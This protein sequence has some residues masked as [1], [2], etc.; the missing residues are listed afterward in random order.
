M[1]SWKSASLP[2]CGVADIS[3]RLRVRVPSSLPELVALRLLHL[4][5]EIGG[6]HA[7]RFV[8]DDEVP[9]W[10][11][12]QL[13]FQFVGARGHVEPHDEAVAF[14]ER[15][16]GER[17]LDLVAR[18]DVEG[19]AEL[20]RHLVLP[21]L[22]ETARRDDQAALQVATDQQ[23]L[24]EEPGHDRFAGAGVV[25]E[26][27]AQRLARQH[28]AVDG[29]DLV[30]QRLDLGGG[31]RE[32]GVEQVREPDAVGF[33]R[34]AQERRRRRRSHRCGPAS[35]NSKAVSSPR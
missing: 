2:L 4:A 21:L 23:F 28:L 26:Q 18:E 33:G 6:R 24:D 1:K 27:E 19:E 7:V 35:T 11:G 8:A 34:E 30:R 17:C 9:V 22:D 25:G 31:D 10:R 12:L 13:R 3:R 14:D 29:S 5:A 32:V 15:I 20:L 16:A